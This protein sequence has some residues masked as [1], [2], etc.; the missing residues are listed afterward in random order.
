MRPSREIAL[1]ELVVGVP[2]ALVVGFA[3]GAL[4]TLK[5]RVGVTGS[6]PLP[7]GL[8]AGILLVAAFVV[9]ARVVL[10]TRLFAIFGALGVIAAVSLYAMEGPGRSVV[11]VGDT[12]GTTWIVASCAVAA[13]LALVP[14]PRRRAGSGRTRSHGVDVDGVSAG[15]AGAARVSGILESDQVRNR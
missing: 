13:L 6:T 12:T 14:F 5:H 1:S 9:A 3:I 4:C 7:I 2:L 8:V 11:V 15:E 10:G